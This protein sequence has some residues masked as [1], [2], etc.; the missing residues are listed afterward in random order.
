M[1]LVPSA[2]DELLQRLCL[3]FAVKDLDTLHYFL[4]VEVFPVKSGILL[5]QQRLLGIY[6]AKPTWRL[7]NQSLLPYPHPQFCQ[8]SWVILW[9]THLY[10]EAQLD[11]SN[12]C[13]LLVQTWHLL[14]IVFVNSCID[15]QNFI[16]KLSRESFGISRIPSLTSCYCRRL[17]RILFKLFQ[18]QI[19]QVALMVDALQ[20]LIAFSLDPI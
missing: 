19:G 7:P 18:M 15:R 11:L 4:G 17:P 10:T 9:R 14:S 3:V 13:P 2:I 20:V 8:H 5:C 12:T 16:G 6:Y 1:S